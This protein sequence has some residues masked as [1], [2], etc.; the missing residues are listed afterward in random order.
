M[1]HKVMS[2]FPQPVLLYCLY[3]CDITV[4]WS[5]HYR[6]GSQTVHISLRECV[7]V[8]GRHFAHKLIQ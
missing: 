7:K 1:L 6:H 4:T 5:T 2:E 3:Q 8:K